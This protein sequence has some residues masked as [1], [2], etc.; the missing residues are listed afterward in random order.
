VG[1]NP[2]LS[3]ILSSYSKAR[4]QETETGGESSRHRIG[5]KGEQSMTG[6]EM[7]KAIAA[8]IAQQTKVDNRIEFLV[9]QQAT[10]QQQQAALQDGLTQLTSVVGKLAEEAAE[11]RQVVGKLAEQAAEDRQAVREA[12]DRFETDISRLVDVVE[13]TRDFAEQVAR[14]AVSS[15]QRLTNLEGRQQ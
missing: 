12:F 11:D 6:E 5:A 13:N 10:F 4:R 14:L 9:E 15:E 8:L 3:A 1:S 7:E 2:T